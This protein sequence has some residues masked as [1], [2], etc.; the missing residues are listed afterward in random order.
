MILGGRE[1]GVPPRGTPARPSFTSVEKRFHVARPMNDSDHFNPSL[2]GAVIN[3]AGARWVSGA[4]RS[5]AP[6]PRLGKSA[7]AR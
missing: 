3:D 7:K 1:V 2:N 6:S 5:G 4:G